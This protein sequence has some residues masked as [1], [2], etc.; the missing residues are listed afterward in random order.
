MILGETHT[1][2]GRR[3]ILR[4]AAHYDAADLIRAVDAVSKERRFFLRS[5]FQLDIDAE[6]AFI[7]QAR[8][9]GDLILLAIVEKSLAGWVTLLRHKQE[10]RRHAGQLGIGVL[11]EYR[12]LGVGKALM[13]TTLEWAVPNRMERVEL[14]VRASNPRARQL[15]ESLGFVQEGH[16]ARSV[17]DDQGA[18]DDD[19][20]MVAF[21]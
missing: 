11:K 10:F 8:R 6:M 3:L 18:Y 15:Y 5:S 1:N 2:D 9:R 21:V 13:A 14:S 16:R 20:L 19:V 12:G 4:E 7:A 17:K